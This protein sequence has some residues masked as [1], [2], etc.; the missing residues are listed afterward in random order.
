[1]LAAMNPYN[2]I[3]PFLVMILLSSK[4]AYAAPFEPFPAD[5]QPALT[6]WDLDG[7]PHSL[8]KYRGEVVLINFWATWCTPCITELPELSQLQKQH[9][10][11]AF[12]IL[13]INVGER[14]SR[15]IQFS[16]S[17][18][19]DLPVF[20]DKDSLIFK[21]WGGHVLPTTLLFDAEGKARYRAL[22]NPG[23]DYKPTT[24]IIDELI[25]QAEISTELTLHI[26]DEKKATQ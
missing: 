26:G 5:Q 18:G 4:L 23:W 20:L 6:L 16:K 17:I 8:E 3:S 11:R 9:Q 12:K 13:T 14:K 25:D 24:D 22:G 19:L 15:V 10:G 21:Q 7:K 1:M 2:L